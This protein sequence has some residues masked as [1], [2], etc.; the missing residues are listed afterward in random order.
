MRKK[1]SLM[2]L[3]TIP[4]RCPDTPATVVILSNAASQ[5]QSFHETIIA[6]SLQALRKSLAKFQKDWGVIP[7]IL[8]RICGSMPKDE[9]RHC[10]ADAAE[11]IRAIR[12]DTEDS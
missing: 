8:Q 9:I 2:S 10:L 6:Y 5:A 11:S 4:V 7:D 3:L 12:Q 1:S